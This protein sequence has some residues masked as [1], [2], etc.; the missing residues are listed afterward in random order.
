MPG[1]VSLAADPVEIELKDKKGKGTAK[2]TAT[3]KNYDDAI[4]LKFGPVK[5]VEFK[6]GT[7]AKGEN[8]AKVEVIV[9]EGTPGDVDVAV[10]GTAENA[11]VE[12]TK[13]KLK[14]K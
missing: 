6:N 12:P 1:S 4:T 9:T 2:I 10:S 3:R 14:L 13:L 7:I 8:S 5:G 11:T